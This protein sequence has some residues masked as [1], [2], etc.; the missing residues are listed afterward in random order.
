VEFKPQTE[1]QIAASKLWKRGVYEFEIVDAFEKLSKSSNRPMIELRVKVTG[2]NGS[3]TVTDYLV[4]KRAEKL[5]HAAEACGL[6]EKY[7]K[8]T[9]T[10]LDFQKKRGKLKLGIEKDKS[11]TYPDKNVVVDYVTGPVT[12]GWTGYAS[13]S[14]TS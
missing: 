13:L 1:A 4:E 3:R 12:S 14:E 9:L 10:N 7:N 2:P 6:I 11:H 5:R 8:G